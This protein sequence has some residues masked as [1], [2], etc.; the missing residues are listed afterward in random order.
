MYTKALERANNNL[1]IS[2]HAVHLYNS[3]KKILEQKNEE[4]NG[5]DFECTPRRLLFSQWNRLGWPWSNKKSTSRPI[6][7]D[8]QPSVD[9]AL[10]LPSINFYLQEVGA[11]PGFLGVVM[12]AYSIAGLIFAPI[13]GKITDHFGKAWVNSFDFL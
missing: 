5:L 3:S 10:I 12:S 7:L 4:K 9:F 8:G 13:L 1:L 6:F 2:S 11:E